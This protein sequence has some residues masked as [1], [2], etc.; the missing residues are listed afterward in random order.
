MSQ[1][2]AP[3]PRTPRPAWAD[4]AD[5]ES[6]DFERLRHFLHAPIRRPWL[7]I[8]PW[9]TVVLLSVVALYTLPKRYRSSTLIL[10]ESEK[11]PESFVPKVATE[12]RSQRLDAIRPEI[13]SRT[14]LEQVIAETQAYPDI[15]STRQAVDLIRRQVSVNASGSDG[16][17]IEYV[18]QNPHKAQEVTSRLAT[19]FIA[20]TIKAREAQVEDAVDFLITQVNAARSELERKEEALRRF[21]EERMGRLPEQLDTN[22]ATM[23][24]LQQELRTVEES[25]LFARER[26]A[27]L[28]RGARP[29]PAAAP[30]EAEITEL[31]RQLAS[32]RGR[33][34]EEHPDVQNLKARIARLEAS[35]RESSSDREPAAPEADGSSI[36]EQLTEADAEIARLETKRR[37]TE[38]RMAVLRARV[39]ETPRTE[40]ELTTLTRDYEKLRDNYSALLAKQLDAQMAGRLERRWR[41]DRFRILDP[42]DLPEKPYFPPRMLVLGIGFLAGLFLGI[43]AAVVAEF[44]DPTVKDV[45]D[46]RTL[47]GLDILVC[48]PHLPS[49]EEPARR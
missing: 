12:E 11:V 5:V 29:R 17:T 14:R 18:H 27:S 46:L 2:S 24:M 9:A 43:G 36:R 42:A 8:I 49:L 38:A 19:L 37:D 28:A 21:K 25:I 41:G 1:S 13:L 23:Q 26:Q 7:V 48:I 3:T 35:V 45:A 10:I 44:L 34:T 4:D 16:F 40:Q 15:V 6:F 32:M 30:G 31:R 22:L 47:Q 33:Y 39:E 20:E